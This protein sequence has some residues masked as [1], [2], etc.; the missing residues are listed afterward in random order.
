MTR[1][2]ACALCAA[3]LALGGCESNDDH[4]PSAGPPPISGG[5]LE[6]VD[7]GRYAIA[8]DP[9]RA[10]IHVVDLESNEAR[11]R[12]LLEEYD[13]P[14]RIA[15][16]QDG[17]VHV[18]LRRAGQVAT[19]DHVAGTVVERRDVC[20]APRGIAV[21][22]D[23]GEL[24]VACA[25]GEL[26]RM[27]AAGGAPT[28]V[29]KLETDLRDVVAHPGGLVLVSRFRA[30]EVLVLQDGA[31]VN[32]VRL[33]GDDG[34]TGFGRT[35][36]PTV[37]WRM[38]PA[39]G[40]AI[41]LHQHS[42]SSQLG[43]LGA[44]A[45]GNQYYGGDCNLGVVRTSVSRVQLADD[46]AGSY[47]VQSL[48]LEE[49]SLGVDVALNPAT[50]DIFVAAGAEPP[51]VPSSAFRTLP[52]QSGVRRVAA[53]NLSSAPTCV[54]AED[55]F[56]R[57]AAAVAVAITPDGHVVAQYRNPGTLEIDGRGTIALSGGRVDDLGHS[58]FHE[59]VGTGATCAGCHPE[60]GDDGHVWQFDVG[61][62]RSQTLTGGILDTAPFHWTGDVPASDQVMA[63]TFVNR[64]G[65]VM[66]RD[67]EIASFER[68]VDALPATPAPAVDHTAAQRGEALFSSAGCTDCHNGPKL[69]NNDTLN[70]G[71]GIM[72][73]VPALYEVAYHAPYLHDGR[74]PT[75]QDLLGMHG[76][77][78]TLTESERDDLA[79]YLT[80]L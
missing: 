27:P 41:L 69:T 3:A 75:L 43:T 10:S 73:Q 2:L 57:D 1:H 67:E 12:I 5:T 68:W 55:P 30:A 49:T 32:T 51:S 16:D 28:D 76:D 80:S 6:L 48:A 38:R 26:V 15:Q 54:S 7:S 13:E 24:L 11:H 22:P 59:A 56:T 9:A 40:G 44:P 29:L 37:A 60:G 50:G 46:P 53:T 8:S 72:A 61:P 63:G 34:T 42:V 77:A 36:E 4:V 62:R 52:G 17:R 79:E 21:D 35:A 14:G 64:M 70:V 78:G 20:A 33:P 74:A 45:L 47:S 18:V 58:L 25:T 65:G 23:S 39:P 71:T 66:P 19:I 31:L